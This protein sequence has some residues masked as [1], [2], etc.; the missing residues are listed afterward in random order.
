MSKQGIAAMAWPASMGGNV[1]QFSF[2]HSQEQ[3][4]TV[5]TKSAVGCCFLS[6][7]FGYAVAGGMLYSTGPN[8][9]LLA[10]VGEV[11]TV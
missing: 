5:A 11:S 9:V 7:V 8:V 10:F 6:L 2:F 1:K 3:M 4:G